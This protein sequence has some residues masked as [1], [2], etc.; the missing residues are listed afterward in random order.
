MNRPLYEAVFDENTTDSFII[1][2]VEQPATMVKSLLFNQE[3]VVNIKL[4]FN[5]EKRIVTSVTLRADYITP[6]NEG[7]DVIFKPEQIEKFRDFYMKNGVRNYIKLGHNT[8]E[9]YDDLVLIESYILTDNLRPNYEEFKEVANGSW[10]TS[11][12]VYNDELW[13]KLKSGEIGG[14]S[15]EFDALLQ[16]DKNKDTLEEELLLLNLIK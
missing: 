9:K 15:P 6:R 8:E 5:D 16:L 12:K 14:I 1:A 13:N 11:W 3:K 2:F 4:A 7:Y 10:I